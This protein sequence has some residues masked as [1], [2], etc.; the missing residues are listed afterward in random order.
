MGAFL[1]VYDEL[2][3]NCLFRIVKNKLIVLIKFFGILAGLVFCGF[4]LILCVT[5][6]SEPKL[7]M[8]VDS[9]E[10]LP[11]TA[12]DISYIEETG[13]GAMRIAEFAMSQADL[14]AYALE[15]EWELVAKEKVSIFFRDEIHSGDKSYQ[16][17][18]EENV[19][20]TALVYEKRY[21]N[22]G[23]I[24]LVYDPQEQRGYYWYSHR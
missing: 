5:W 4:I 2:Y 22:G 17:P 23:G 7:E 6:T 16:R 20:D 1:A 13:M 3:R 18:F 10:W 11:S 8:H 12:S 24:T 15:N 19:L 21:H 14:Y 9:V